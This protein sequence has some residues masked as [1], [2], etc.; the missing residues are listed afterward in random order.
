MYQSYRSQSNSQAEPKITHQKARTQKNP[1]AVNHGSYHTVYNCKGKKGLNS[2]S[3]RIVQVDDPHT[4][5]RSSVDTG[6]GDRGGAPAEFAV[7]AETVGCPEDVSSVVLRYGGVEFEQHNRFS[8]VPTNLS[9]RASESLRFGESLDTHGV[10]RVGY[11]G[12]QG[13]YQSFDIMLVCNKARSSSEPMTWR[14]SAKVSQKLGRVQV[15]SADSALARRGSESEGVSQESESE[16]ERERE[17]ERKRER[18]R[19][20]DLFTQLADALW[21]LL[22]LSTTQGCN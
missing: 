10:S 18:L 4:A 1:Q 6:A 7:V 11:T 3:P 21:I 15:A 8:V 12:E 20:A 19:E 13:V 22:S 5:L 9:L 14:V 16:R 17:R 2:E